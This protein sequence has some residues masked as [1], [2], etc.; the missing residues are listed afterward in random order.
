MP[1]ALPHSAPTQNPGKLA[2]MRVLVVGLPFRVLGPRDVGIEDANRTA[3][4]RGVR[5]NIRAV[6]SRNAIGELQCG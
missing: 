3:D 4:R 5:S 2:E 1:P 6:M